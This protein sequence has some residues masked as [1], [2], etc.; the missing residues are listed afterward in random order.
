MKV[1]EESGCGSPTQVP[2]VILFRWSPKGEGGF[3]RP[4]GRTIYGRLN[5]WDD[6]PI[7]LHELGSD[8][9]KKGSAG[10]DPGDRRSGIARRDPRG[11]FVSRRSAPGAGRIGSP[12]PARRPRSAPSASPASTS[13]EGWNR[14]GRRRTRRFPR[15]RRRRFGSRPRIQETDSVGT[16]ACASWGGGGWEKSGRPGIS[17]WEDGSP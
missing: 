5:L 17:N 13:P 7:P 2:F 9:E 8:P 4:A 1:S 14:S 12:S 16:F 10:D 15:K 11:E 6:S 3:R